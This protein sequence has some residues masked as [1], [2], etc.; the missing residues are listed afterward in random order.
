[1][2]D[3]AATGAPQSGLPE[4][5]R[6]A[7]ELP[8]ARF[9][10]EGYNAAEVDEFV[11]DLQRALR[12]EPPAMAPYEIADQRFK[13]SRFGRRYRLREV[14]EYLDRAQ[15][16]FRERHGGDAVALVEGRPPAPHHVRTWWIYLI[17]LVIAGLLVAFL[18]TQL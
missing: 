4:P 11:E 6:P 10:R 2:N 17:A 13:V 15:E 5:E 1:V 8:T 16:Q 7:P 9:P 14:D 12:R 18:L 3:D